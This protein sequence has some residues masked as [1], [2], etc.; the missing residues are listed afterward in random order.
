M[1][2]R[3]RQQEAWRHRGGPKWL[4][5]AAV[6]GLL[7][8]TEGLAEEGNTNASQ[9]QSAA[10]E[11]RTAGPVLP[12]L[13]AELPPSLV[14]DAS[15]TPTASDSAPTP[16]QPSP[17]TVASQAGLPPAAGTGA[18]QS[19]GSLPGAEAASADKGR[20]PA[21]VAGSGSEASQR[22]YT[23]PSLVVEST[24]PQRAMVGQPLKHTIVV[25]NMG[26]QVAEQISL[27]AGFSLTCEVLQIVPEATVLNGSELLWPIGR[28]APGQSREVHVVLRPLESGLF[29][30][31]ATVQ[32]A[33][34]SRVEV[35]VEAPKL[36]LVISGPKGL[37][38]G[39]QATLQVRVR[40]VGSVPARQVVVRQVLSGVKVAEHYGIEPF[41]S[42]LGTLGPGEVRDL[43]VPLYGWG[44]GKALVRLEALSEETALTAATHEVQ[45]RAPAL[46]L[47][48]QGP[49]RRYVGRLVDYALQ[50]RNTG[51]LPAE[52]LEA[53]VYLPAQA[54]FHR[55]ERNGHWDP[56][57]RTIKWTLEKL[58]P[59]ASTEVRMTVRWNQEGEH[60]VRAAALDHQ[61]GTV[62]KIDYPVQAEGYASLIVQAVD[63]EDP[64]AVGEPITYE[65]YVLNR[66]TKPASNTHLTVE[67]SEDLHLV[68]V[69]GPVEHEL[70]GQTIH[71][72]PVV[73][74]EPR[75]IYTFRLKGT[76]LHPGVPT[77]RATATSDSVPTSV[78]AEQG[79]I[80]TP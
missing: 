66:G 17:K 64:V 63:L 5:A 12:G 14:P 38:K 48:I 15:A 36:D 25:R 67:L 70:K 45:I 22:S 3:R 30:C 34:V 50:V 6:L 56:S 35:P 52:A 57:L 58:P 53:I 8:G 69:Q 60:L 29:R 75:R 62:C 61:T 18:S 31:T 16:A 33:A 23:N 54:E 26:Q 41:R 80:V 21:N 44:P 78:R 68:E 71:F 19:R 49:Q 39:G 73:E 2:I 79:T 77:I 10:A 51:D 40:N 9:K 37:R 72:R 4:L 42:E 28:L 13:P 74:L 20:D 65:I 24:A 46:E 32:L 1:G 76:A 43:T 47:Q 7:Y 55:A 27:R 11:N 59:H